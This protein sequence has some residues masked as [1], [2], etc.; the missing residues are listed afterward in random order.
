MNAAGKLSAYGAV[1][2][3]V[4]GGAWAVGTAVGPLSAAPAP[5]SH[6]GMPSGDGHGNAHGATVAETDLPGGLASSR[7]G[8]TF[9]STAT[10]RN[11]GTTEPFSF[12][13][14]GPDGRAVTAFDVE[15]DKRMHLIVVRRDTAGFQHLHPEMAA[16][17]TWST[18][19]ELP[20]AGSYRVFADFTPTGGAATTLGTDIAAAGEFE[21]RGYAPSRVAEVDGYQVRLDGELVAGQSS[22]LRLTVS[23]DGAPVTDLQPYL[24][25][26]GHLVALRGG[27]LAY[28]HVHPEGAPGDGRTAPGPQI[29]FV[30]AVPSA[31]TYRLFLDFQHD[32]VVRTAEFT[33]DTSGSAPAADQPGHTGH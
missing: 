21:P 4:A 20:D 16:D 13:V 31:D 1:L 25:A 28:L 32:G 14:L 8:Y 12:R 23:K 22:P 6:D 30:A 27:D 7:G 26:Y 5:S 15:H 2:A 9:T 18:P 17:G 24:S 19:L 33:V 10:T 3:L 11:A 29:D